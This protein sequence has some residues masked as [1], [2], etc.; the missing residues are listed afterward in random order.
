MRALA[1]LN[2]WMNND[3]EMNRENFFE[4][5][6]ASNVIN[7]VIYGIPWYVDTRLIFYRKDILQEVGA[8]TFPTSWKAWRE[9]MDRIKDTVGTENFAIFLPIE[10]WTTVTILAMELD[11][12]LLADRDRYGA[13]DGPWFREA[14][15]YY[16]TLFRDKLAPSSAGTQI[17]KPVSGF[18]RWVFR[19]VREWPLEHRGT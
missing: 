1:D 13:F 19:H 5:V 7:G 4:G 12:P 18:Y 14:L 3:P 9:T 10:D 2:P 16:L 17:A 8:T 11:A 6:L 15:K